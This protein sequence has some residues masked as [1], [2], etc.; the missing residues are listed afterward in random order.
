MSPLLDDPSLPPLSI[1]ARLRYDVVSQLVDAL[2]PRS[3]LEIGC[4]QGAVGARLAE[5]SAYVGVEPD[6]QSCA[7]ARRGIEPR[8]GVVVQ[9]TTGDV[10]AGR[11]FDL[12]CAFEVLEHIEDDEEALRAW[13]KRMAPGGRLALSVPADQHRFGPMD[14]LVG[15]YRRYDEA[16]LDACVT[17]AG[18]AVDSVVRYGWPLTY[19]LEGVRNRVDR[20]RRADTGG[21]AKDELSAASGRTFQPQGSAAGRAVQLGTLPFRHLQRLR[22]TAGT[23]LVLVAKR[24]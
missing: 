17:G 1:R 14:E 7:V 21:R 20:R 4:G 16:S 12:V 15:H 5:R 2:R 11:T 19:A 6:P 8:G 18:L 22:P 13:A 3:V 23:G 24:P 10:E 9:G